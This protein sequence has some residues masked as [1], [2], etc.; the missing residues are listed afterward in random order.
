MPV[1]I[2]AY[3]GVDSDGLLGHHLTVGNHQIILTTCFSA[4]L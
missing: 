4:V 1:I 2:L 3:L